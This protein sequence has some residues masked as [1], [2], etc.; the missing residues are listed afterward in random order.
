MSFRYKPSP[1]PDRLGNY[2]PVRISSKRD[3]YKK[4]SS[5]YDHVTN[6]TDTY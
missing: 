4:F 6:I 3:Y 5:G 2:P 1:H